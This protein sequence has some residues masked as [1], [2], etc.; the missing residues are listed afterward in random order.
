MGA[1]VF[2]PA[3]PLLPEHKSTDPLAFEL[4]AVAAQTARLLDGSEEAVLEAVM[5]TGATGR[6]PPA[7]LV[8]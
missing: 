5:L 8:P 1:L 7:R 6:R 2:E 3:S 4:G